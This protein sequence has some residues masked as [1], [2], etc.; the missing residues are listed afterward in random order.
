MRKRLTASIITAVAGLAMAMPGVGLASKGG[1]PHKTPAKCGLHKHYG[2]HKGL[3]KGKK[4]GSSKG[5]KCDM[6]PATSGTSKT[7]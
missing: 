4:K 1:H 5:N 7:S 3:T 6:P 2:H